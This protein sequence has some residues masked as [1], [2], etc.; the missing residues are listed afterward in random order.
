MNDGDFTSQEE[1][2]HGLHMLRSATTSCTRAPSGRQLQISLLLHLLQVVQAHDVNACYRMNAILIVFIPVTLVVVPLL[3]WW[4]AYR[5]YRVLSKNLVNIAIYLIL[6]SFTVAGLLAL[7]VEGLGLEENLWPIYVN[8]A[9]ELEPRLT[10]TIFLHD[11]LEH[12]IFQD[13]PTDHELKAKGITFSSPVSPIEQPLSSASLLWNMYREDSPPTIDIP[14]LSL[15][16]ILSQ[17]AL[18]TLEKDM[19]SVLK[20]LNDKCMH[21]GLIIGEYISQEDTHL[22]ERIAHE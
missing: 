17:D 15:E 16:E 19:L 13:L 4:A 11:V 8:L 9:S 18:Q 12:D 5:A 21:Y 14:H 3:L 1:I 7:C 6:L 10:S 20:A 22:L 2:R